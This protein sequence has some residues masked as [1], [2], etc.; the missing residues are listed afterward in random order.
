MVLTEDQRYILEKAL[1]GHSMVVLGQSGT[2]KSFLVKEIAKELRKTGKLVQITATTGIA[3]VNIGG[4]TVHS[5]S[6][7]SDGRYSND[8][9]LE[10]LERNEHFGIYKTNITS[11]QCL[12]I[13]E[14]SML[15]RKLFEQLEYICR[16]I[17]NSSLVFGGLQVIVVGDFFQLPPV[18]D[19]L[20][21]DSGEYCFKSPVFDKIFCHK[22]ILKEVMRQNQDD[23]I[24]A[25]N[26]VSRGD[27]PENTLNLI[28]RLSRHLPPGEDPIRLCARNFDCYIYNA[29]KLMDMD[30]EEVEV[31]ASCIFAPG[32]LGVAIGRAR[33]KKGLRII[34]FNESSIMRHEPETE[35]PFEQSVCAYYKELLKT[36][37]I[38]IEYFVNK[39]Y[40]IIN[41][42]FTKT[43][44]DVTK[45]STE[46]KIWTKYYT[47]LYKFSTSNEY[48]SLV[49]LISHCEPTGQDFEMCSKIY[50]KVTSVVLQKHTEHLLSSHDVNYNKKNTMSDSGKGKLRYIFGRC[51]AKSRFH[52]MK[53][54]KTNMY[55]KKNRES[56]AKSFIKVKMLDSLTKNY[57]ELVQDSKYKKTLLETHRKQSLSQGLTNIT[58]ET[59]EFILKVDEKRLSVQQ[60]KV[61]H[62]YGADF[63]SHCHNV[64]LKDTNLF[65]IWRILFQSFDYCNNYLRIVHQTAEQC[66]HELFEDVV[67]RFCRIAD[68]QFRKDFL[69][70][71]GKSKTESLRKRVDSKHSKTVAPSILNMKNIYND[72]SVSKQSTHF[73]L[74]S[75]I[76]DQGN[77]AFVNFVKND[78]LKLCKSYDIK[79]SCSSSNDVIK[80]KL[81]SKIPSL[82]GFSHPQYLQQAV[83][84]TTTVSTSTKSKHA[85]SSEATQSTSGEATPSTPSEATPSTSIRN[86]SATQPRRRKRKSKFTTRSQRKSS[87]T[88]NKEEKE[89]VCPLC[90]SVYI[91]GDDWIACDLCDLWYDRKCLN[92][93]DDQWDDLEGSDWYC[94]D[95]LK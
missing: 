85:T 6:G 19:Y 8:S 46:P 80:Q 40:T 83:S 59:Y 44:G 72:K 26:D 93:N 14:I 15:S 38:D 39:L 70:T 5:W 68:N 27:I 34:G 58:D 4:K 1:K 28:K 22:I 79:M 78:L 63:L 49:K 7:I 60:E 81:C 21:M 57:T 42:L 53:H 29:C 50:D 89:T 35:A 74:K 41:D 36:Q 88:E 37:R 20:K 84:D 66:L 48:I 90:Q 3:S 24:Q 55:K 75:A 52:N 13:D 77:S 71:V 47:E 94:P 73:K 64:L 10:K 16:K 12:I 61:F 92:L 82:E 65:N 87:K 11:T 62:L 76:F 54:A 30:G 17:V 56:L 95:C 2:G 18:P 9:L 51:I 91:D 67:H 33:E 45:K 43:C 31:D 23:F 32:Q 86:T 69:M 25:I